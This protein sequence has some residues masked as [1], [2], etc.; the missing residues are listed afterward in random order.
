MSTTTTNYKLVKPELTDTADITAT[1]TN[2]DTI[3]AELKEH[4]TKL[5]GL[6]EGANKYVHPTTAGN[7]HIPTGGSSGQILRY[8]SN[9]EAKW[10]NETKAV[11]NN[12]TTTEAGLMSP[13]DK[14]KLDSIDPDVSNYIL[15]VAGAALGGVKSGGDITVAS[16]GTV[17]VNDNSHSHNASNINAGTLSSDRL[18][19]ISVDKGGTGA[20]DASTARTNLGITPANIGAVP[21]SRTING[22]KLTGNITLSASDVGATKVTY[23]TSELTAGTSELAT[24]SVY[25]MYE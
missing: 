21:T 23:G 3:D 17:S 8:A 16:D 19:T 24:G 4:D 5:S 13:E 9:G 6:D 12:A 1:N 18:P 11:Y 22:K 25:M 14:E 15:P 20:T 2:W 7:K 10:D